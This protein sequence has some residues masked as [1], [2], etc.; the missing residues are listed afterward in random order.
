MINYTLTNIKMTVFFF[1]SFFQSLLQTAHDVEFKKVKEIDKLKR[2]VKF[3][4][5]E[6]VANLVSII[7]C[8]E[9]EIYE[10]N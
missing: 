1:N 5:P 3:L 10:T 2:Q 4:T 9:E 7:K 8:V 6:E